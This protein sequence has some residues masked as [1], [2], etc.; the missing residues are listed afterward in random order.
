MKVNKDIETTSSFEPA[1]VEKM[2][3]ELVQ[4]FKTYRPTVGEI[5]IAYGNLGFALGASIEGY[6]GEGPTLEQVKEMYYKNPTLGVALMAHSVE[7]C[8]WYDTY[9]KTREKEVDTK[10]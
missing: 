10:E 1:K 8:G 5:L 2:Y 6:K 9:N 4:V 3:E 7:V